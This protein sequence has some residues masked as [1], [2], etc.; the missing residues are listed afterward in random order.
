MMSKYPPS[1]VPTYDGPMNGETIVAARKLAVPTKMESLRIVLAA[2]PAVWG[3]FLPI[4]PEIYRVAEAGKPSCVNAMNA[5]CAVISRATT[6][7][8][9]GSR[10]R[11]SAT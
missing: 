10:T 7:T 2:A 11:A 6:V 5:A 3:S 8:S 9:P 4:A 1:R